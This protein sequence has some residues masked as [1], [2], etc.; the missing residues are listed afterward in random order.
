MQSHRTRKLP[1]KR[2][3]RRTST[4]R[5]P[6]INAQVLRAMLETAA[7]KAGVLRAQLEAA[8]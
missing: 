3:T 5:E 2:D 1:K 6:S 4:G 7:A 8:R